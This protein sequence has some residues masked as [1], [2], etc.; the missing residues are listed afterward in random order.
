[1]NEILFSILGVGVDLVCLG[2]QPL[3]AV[4][5]IKFTSKSK[6]AAEDTYSIPQWINLSYYSKPDS[7]SSV[8]VPRMTVPE[9]PH[10]KEICEFIRNPF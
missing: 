7:K 6:N 5:L 3:H 9:K 10:P 4:P 2:E 1:M 8:F